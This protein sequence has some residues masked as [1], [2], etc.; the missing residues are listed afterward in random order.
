MRETLLSLQKLFRLRPCE[1]TFFANRS[2]PCLQYQINRCS[3]PCV[4]L[5]TPE[6]YAQDVADAVKVLDGP[7]AIAR[8]AYRLASPQVTF[9]NTGFIDLRT[10]GSGR[11]SV[12]CSPSASR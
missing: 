3:G 4:R 8:Y 1:D 9:D 7:F 11:V 2:R 12:G 6:A 10:T 5:V